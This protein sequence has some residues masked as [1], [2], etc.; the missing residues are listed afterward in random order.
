MVDTIF[1]KR[2]Y[3]DIN[4]E[5][6]DI[7]IS[8]KIDHFHVIYA[9]NDFIKKIKYFSMNK[10]FMTKFLIDTNVNIVVT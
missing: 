3:E 8:S 9:K 6:C 1:L 4:D 7:K 10:Q 2:H 5:F